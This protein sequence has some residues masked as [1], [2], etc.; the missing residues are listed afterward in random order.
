[1]AQAEKAA[2][3]TGAVAGFLG[4][5]AKNTGDYTMGSQQTLLLLA[6]YIH[7]EINQNDLHKYTGVE[8]SSNSRNLQALGEGTWKATADSD[9]K[10]HKRGLGL[11]EGFRDPQDQRN[12]LI[13]LTPQGRAVIEH[14]AT[15]VA[16]YFN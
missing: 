15:E 6:L 4:A 7:P 14:A 9:R 10:I 5:L 12:R 1:M 8:R 13:R 2:R 3:V 11:V 16:H